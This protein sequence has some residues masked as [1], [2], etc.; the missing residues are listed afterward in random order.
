MRASSLG[1]YSAYKASGVPWLGDVPVH[2]D[3]VPNRSVLKPEKQVVGNDSDKYTLLSLTKQGVIPR[4]M[5]NPEG[6]FPSSFDTYQVVEPG[7]LIFCLFDIDETPRAVGLSEMYGM[8]TGAYTR[9]TLRVPRTSRFIFLLYLFLDTGKLLKPLYSGL[10]KVITKSAFLSAKLALPPESER[11]AIVRYLRYVDRRIGRYVRAKEQLIGLLEEEKQAVINQAVTRGLDPK[12]RLKTSGVKWLGDVP[13]H[14]E[15]VQLGRTGVFSK[16]S[17][18]T[19]D[20][21]V[22][23][24]IPCVRYGDLYTTHKYFINQ[25]R[26]YISPTKANAYTP[27]NR[28]EILFPTSGETIEEIGKSAVNL[29]DSKILCGGDLIIWRPTIPM[30]PKF[31]GY[32]LDCPAAQTQKSLMGRGI[33]IMHIYSGQLKY[34]WLPLPTLSEQ[35]AIVDYLDK[36]IAD[37]DAAIARAHRQIQL[38]EE[39]RT[40][41]IADVVTGKLDVREAAAGLPDEADAMAEDSLSVDGVDEDLRDADG[42]S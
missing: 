5:E 36:A 18:G 33:T 22:T 32:A 27:I 17:G 7:N 16:G 1:P 40:R 30:E 38:L 8:I 21:E 31:G 29:M 24:G 15:V 26:S 28:S 39:Y 10:R 12:V 14:W 11:V 37:I 9:F 20:D 4:D 34:L 23:D 42:L 3:L 2:W 19:K 35:T 41:L 6:K 13:E 25:T